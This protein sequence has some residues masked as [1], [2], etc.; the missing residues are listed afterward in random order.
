[1]TTVY[2][3]GPM[4][5]I[6]DLNFPAFNAAAERFRGVGAVVVNPAELNPEP[7]KSWGECMRVDIAA[8]MKCDSIF[9]LAGWRLS[10]GATLEHHIAQSLGMNIGGALE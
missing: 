3:S 7:G 5:G 10:R 2:I 1:M 4:T 6:P 9:M 8:L